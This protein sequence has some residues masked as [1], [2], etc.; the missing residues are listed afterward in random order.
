VLLL[1]GKVQQTF[2]KRLLPTY[3]VFD[4]DRYFEAGQG[5]QVFNLHLADGSYLRIGVTI[6][7]DIWNDEDFWGRRSYAND[8]V[9]ELVENHN[10]DLLLNLSA[11]PYAVGKQSL[12]EAMLKHR[13]IAHNLLKDLK[14]IC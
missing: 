11:S 14:R 1:G 12:R 8:P 10:L 3:D 4:E 6:C 2:Y 13:A 9:A 5:S 7:E